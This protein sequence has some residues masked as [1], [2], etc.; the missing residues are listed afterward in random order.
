MT[1][2]EAYNELVLRL[3]G[4]ASL[5]N[6]P[7]ELYS[8]VDTASMEMGVGFP[9]TNRLTI[10]WMLRRSYRHA[11]NLLL[12]ESAAKFKYKQ[13][14]LQNRFDHYFQLVQKEDRDW[15]IAQNSAELIAA[16]SGR[17]NASF[18]GSTIR[19]G[20]KYDEAGRETTHLPAGSGSRDG[21]TENM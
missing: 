15:E 6:A 16:A 5:F 10:H 20:F 3:K 18:F 4:L 11:L 1:A 13:I 9:L 7:D 8:C 12:T 14:N 21:S 17:G 2:N 19:A